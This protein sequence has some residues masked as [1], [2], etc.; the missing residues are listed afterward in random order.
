MVF[1]A[2]PFVL[3]VILVIFGFGKLSLLASLKKEEE[4]CLKRGEEDKNILIKKRRSRRRLL[5]LPRTS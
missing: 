1:V 4:D 2:K 5:Y 3:L